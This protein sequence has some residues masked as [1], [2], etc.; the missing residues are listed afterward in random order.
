MSRIY[1]VY[2]RLLVGW[3]VDCRHASSTNGYKHT[4]SVLSVTGNV[5]P[6]ILCFS[7][8]DTANCSP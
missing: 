8:H 4:L 5:H 3:L 2:M 1:A 6:G 7:F